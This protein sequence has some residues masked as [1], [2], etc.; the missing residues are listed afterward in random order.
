MTLTRN[1]LRNTWPEEIQNRVNDTLLTNLIIGRPEKIRYS[2]FKQ[3]L[4]QTFFK[5]VK[6]TDQ[7]LNEVYLLKMIY[8]PSQLNSLPPSQFFKKKE[9]KGISFF[10]NGQRE[11]FALTKFYLPTE[12][13][14][15][16]MRVAVRIQDL[17][18]AIL[19]SCKKESNDALM[20][21]LSMRSQVNHPN[22]LP[23]EAIGEINQNSLIKAVS[24]FSPSGTLEQLF[25]N[26]SKLENDSIQKNCFSYFKAIIESLEA[27]H[28]KGIV[29]R[30]L[31]PRHILIFQPPGVSKTCLIKLIDFSKACFTDLFKLSIKE[32]CRKHIK[33]TLEVSQ[34]YL[35]PEQ[36]L[37]QEAICKDLGAF[38]QT[39][40]EEKLNS[41]A[42]PASDIWALGC[43]FYHL[44]AGQSFSFFNREE[45]GGEAPFLSFEFMQNRLDERLNE[46]PSQA[47]FKQ[48]MRE[49]A[50]FILILKV[51]NRPSLA[52]I[53][54]KLELVEHQLDLQIPCS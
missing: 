50:Q 41:L 22:V 30:N 17:S 2:C 39:P 5:A 47:P 16:K 48:A 27:L 46:H 51:E 11:L 53:K 38:A 23:L 52:E 4:N 12:T 15:K 7:H 34:S 26:L 42:S 3:L 21:D 54:Q 19:Y 31:H 9:K 33:P 20:K 10:T 44:Y 37:A 18:L 36:Y 43:L 24:L 49:M 35:A 6:Q 28:K 13:C 8:S 1:Y 32:Q 40:D 45:Q 29:H 25:N 14:T